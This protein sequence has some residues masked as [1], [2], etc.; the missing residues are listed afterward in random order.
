MEAVMLVDLAFGA[1][2]YVFV[3]LAFG[4]GFEGVFFSLSLFFS[5]MPDL[6]LLPYFGIKKVS[7]YLLERRTYPRFRGLFLR[8]KNMVTHHIIHF[9]LFYFVASAIIWYFTESVYACTLFLT[10]SLIHL[11]HDAFTTEQGIQLFWPFSPLGLRLSRKGC[12]VVTL[13]ER[14]EIMRLRRERYRTQALGVKGEV[15][16][17]LEKVGAKTWIMISLALGAVTLFALLQS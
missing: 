8:G 13:E 11:V 7:A 4:R 16:V 14:E 1:I 6:D 3:S 9:P 2:I 12:H 5:I 10:C 15:L 17:R